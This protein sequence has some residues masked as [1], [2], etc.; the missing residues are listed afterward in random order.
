MLTENIL[1]TPILLE[2]AQ[3]IAASRQ[4]MSLEFSQAAA[5]GI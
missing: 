5:Y 3:Y 1:S 4:G 2:A